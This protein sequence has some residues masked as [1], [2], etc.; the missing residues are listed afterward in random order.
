MSW[1]C[2]SF[3]FYFLLGKCAD[4]PFVIYSRSIIV[5]LFDG[6]ED[7]DGAVPERHIPARFVTLI[8]REFP[9]STKKRRKSTTDGGA[10]KRRPSSVKDTSVS[11]DML[12]GMY[13]HSSS[14]VLRNDEME[15]N[16]PNSTPPPGYE[17][18]SRRQSK[19]QQKHHDELAS[20]HFSG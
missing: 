8:P 17:K 4:L 10:K 6:D 18:Q 2:S 13:G 5:V 12:Q 14:N 16:T 3:T 11:V 1:G 9:S 20:S 15:F 19:K 7:D